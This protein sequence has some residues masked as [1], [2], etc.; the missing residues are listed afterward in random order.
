M[1]GT[2]YDEPQI[3]IIN[4]ANREALWARLLTSLCGEGP[5]GSAQ[6]QFHAR[7][8]LGLARLYRPHGSLYQL[9]VNRV[10]VDASYI[11]LQQGPYRG[12]RL[13]TTP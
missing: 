7:L 10:E 2:L 8:V 3:Q 9:L 4:W 1:A 5:R 6:I 12:R 11:E 13:V